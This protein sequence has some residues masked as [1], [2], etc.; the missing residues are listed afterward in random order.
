MSTE[1]LFQV[2]LVLGYLAWLLCLRVYV[3]PRLKSMDPFEAQRA[4]ATLHSFRFFGLVFILPGVVSPHLPASF[5]VFAAYGDFA[6]G[7][8]AMLAL[9][10]ARIRPLFWLF[11]VAFNLVGATDLIL[12][13][14]HAIQSGLPARAGEFGATYAIP[15]IYVPVLMITHIAAFYLLLRP[16]PRPA[17]SYLSFR[18]P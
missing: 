10:T 4:I 1:R 12:D 14:Y 18:K 16:Q 5:A 13:Y 3:W 17:R 2:H 7:V 6:T 11:V 9:L 15:V 8:L